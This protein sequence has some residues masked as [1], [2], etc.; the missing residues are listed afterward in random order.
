VNSIQE[1]QIKGL[2]KEILEV[3]PD[4]KLSPALEKLMQS[5]PKKMTLQEAFRKA[6]ERN[7]EEVK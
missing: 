1:R 6:L 4:A 2:A 3:C 5:K 7:S